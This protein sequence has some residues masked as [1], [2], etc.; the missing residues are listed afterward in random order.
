MKD[1][2]VTVWKH[3]RV[4]KDDKSLGFHSC[5]P[6]E[7]EA[8]IAAG[9]AQ[10]LR[11]GAMRFKRIDRSEVDAVVVVEAVEVVNEVEVAEQPETPKAKK[12]PKEK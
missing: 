12:A 8:L 3:K 4:N 6:E 2:K 11:V 7:A 9:V 5:T 10:D 1:N